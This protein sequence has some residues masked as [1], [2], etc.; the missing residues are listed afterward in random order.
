[1]CVSICVEH[2]HACTRTHTHTHTHKRNAGC[3][4]YVHYVYRQYAC[5]CVSLCMYTCIPFLARAHTKR[6]KDTRA[7]YVQTIYCKGIIWVCMCIYLCVDMHTVTDPHNN[8]NANLT[9]KLASTSNPS[10]TLTLTLNK[11]KLNT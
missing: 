6:E 11:L 5:L 7:F 3:V 1:M 2:T 9:I 8:S 4:Q 10:L